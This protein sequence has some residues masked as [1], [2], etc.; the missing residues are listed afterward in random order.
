MKTLFS[1]LFLM[2]SYLYACSLCATD[3]PQVVVNAEISY[4]K[5]E[6]HFDI[7]WKFH[8]EFVNSL[9]QYDLN[10]NYIFDPNEKDMIKESLLVYIKSLHYLTDIEFKN[11]NKHTE[12]KFIETIHPTFSQLKFVEGAMIYHYKF[13]L[14]FVLENKNTLYLGFSDEND[15]FAFTL[16]NLI[17]NNYPH[18]FF[19][20]KK[21]FNA[22]IILDDPSIIAPQKTLVM[23]QDIN[24]SIQTKEPIQVQ[25]KDTTYIE[26]LS[27][28]LTLLKN[29]LK[30]ILKDIK[31]NNSI[32]SYMWLLIFSFLYGILHAVGPGHGKSLVSS[33]F[34]NQDKSYLKAFSIASLIGVVHTFSAFILT[35]VVYYSIGFIFNSTIVNVE[36]IATQVSAIIIICIA[37]YLIFKKVKKSKPSYTFTANVKPSSILSPKVTHTQSLSC[38]CNGCKTTSTDLGVILAAG[39]IPC[40]GTVTIF[41]F[42]M[43]LGIYF[44]GF[45]SAIF[46]S[47]GMSL[48]IFLTAVISVT[49][50]K[51]TSQNTAIIKFFEYFSLAF[52]LCLGIFLLLAS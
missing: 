16:K 13:S 43:S 40:P 35:L 28:K 37:L 41:L 49:I 47:A 52:I 23:S 7:N 2:Q 51:S 44:V 46:M 31:E 20:E 34:I 15:N 4:D 27:E 32:S 12:Q 38:G 19:L 3:I 26:L 21:L 5:N 30:T 14:P 45:V 48:I 18:S 10:Q 50:R 25:Q 42:T 8:K 39:I 36:Q 9:T 6:T 17:I 29:N 22:R 24:K 33:Y 11:I 1:L